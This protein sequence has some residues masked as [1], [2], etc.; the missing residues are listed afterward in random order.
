MRTWGSIN[1]GGGIRI[2]RSYGP[3]DLGPPRHPRGG[4]LSFGGGS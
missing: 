3:E 2:G 1:I 4:A